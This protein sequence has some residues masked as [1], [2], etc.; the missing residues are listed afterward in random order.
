MR[1]PASKPDS[2][3]TREGSNVASAASKTGTRVTSYDVARYLGVSQ[4]TVSRVFRSDKSTSPEMRRRVLEAADYLEYQPNAAARSL[5]TRR[6]TLVA[7]LVT[8][9]TGL[10]YPTLITELSQGFAAHDLRLVP[11]ILR[12]ENDIDVA[13]R[14][15][16]RHQVA[17]VVAAVGLSSAQVA[18]LAERD[19]P[20]VFYNRTY[21]N[22][23]AS[24]ICCDQLHGMRTIASNLLDA[25][26]LSFLFL[27]GP[28]DSPVSSER[29][30]GFLQ[31]VREA[32]GTTVHEARG[33]MDMNSGWDIIRKLSREDLPDAIVCA[34]DAIAIGALEA[35]RHTHA[36]KVP[37][38][39]SITG[40]DGLGP[41]EWPSYAITTVRQPVSIMFRATV[42]VLTERIA[43]PTLPP[44]Q[45]LVRGTFVPGRTARIGSP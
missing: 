21:G 24:S 14:Q 29:R 12:G 35:V 33:G 8:E 28:T 25:G 44:V 7:L 43:D 31:T 19:I 34:N 36:M 32:E 37:N 10:N 39:I 30:K 11:F 16:L 38:E 4:S 13:I 15:F 18:V 17:G 23:A 5:I 42:E 3:S 41:A 9:H 2:A 6:S 45:T 22:L 40:F 20:V 1:R 27:A 26:H